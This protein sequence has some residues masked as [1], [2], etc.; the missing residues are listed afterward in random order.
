[1]QNPLING[2][3]YS[4]ADIEFTVTGQRFVGV[5]EINYDDDLKRAKVYG[6]QKSPLGLTTGKYEANGDVE[7]LLEAAVL[8]TQ[9]LALQGA[10]FGGFRFVPMNVTVS[11]TTAGLN[12]PLPLVTDSFVCYL[13]KQDAKNKVSDEALTRKFGLYLPSVITW[14]GNPGVTDPNSFGAFG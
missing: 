5:T 4:Y 13:G 10:G 14:N 3:Y 12:N 1:V 9:T 6:T 8:L 7:F 2:F 11:Y